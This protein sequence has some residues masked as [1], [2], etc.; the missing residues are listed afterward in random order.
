MKENK[1]LEY[2]SCCLIVGRFVA[3]RKIYFST[4][5]GESLSPKIEIMK[6]LKYPNMVIL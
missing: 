6:G 5:E 3:F 4:S 2:V 1:K